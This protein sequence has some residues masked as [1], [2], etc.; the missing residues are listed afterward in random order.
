MEIVYINTIFRIMC[1]PVRCDIN[2]LYIFDVIYIN[3]TEL[4]QLVYESISE[5]AE[6]VSAAIL[7]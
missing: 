6:H 5:Y 1:Q 2:T 3:V 7:I 4:K